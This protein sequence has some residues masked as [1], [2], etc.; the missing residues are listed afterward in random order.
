MFGDRNRR[1]SPLGLLLLS[2]GFGCSIGGP[3]DIVVYTALD[4]PFSEPVFDTFTERTQIGV[5]VKYDTE[6]NKTVGLTNLILHEAA[7]PRC[8]LFWNNEILNTLRLEQHGLLAA[9]QSP[10]ADHFPAQYRSPTGHWYGFAARARVL[11]VN[12]DRVPSDRYPRSIEDLVSPE[13][14]GSAGFAKPL[15]GTTATHFACLY[16]KWGAAKTRRFAEQLH[17]QAKLFP[18]NRQVAHAVG[19]GQLAF[20]LTDTD[21]AVIERKHGRPVS[22]IYPDQEVGALGT[23]L[24]PNTVALIQNSRHPEA[25][26]QLLDFLLSSN[27]ERQLA[28]GKSSQIPL[29]TQIKPAKELQLPADLRLMQVDFQFA[30][31]QWEPCARMLREVFL[32]T[33]DE[34]TSNALIS[35]TRR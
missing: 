7:R 25:A 26:R 29:N 8:D 4:R 21:D 32:N 23:L 3:D 1:W 13:W 28:A 22:I 10:Q 9:Y 35:D 34:S 15:F 18:G 19:T 27:V 6:A 5:R 31:R 12:H 33:L 17:R 2:A 20:G 11:L 14:N 24:V 16:A 30:A